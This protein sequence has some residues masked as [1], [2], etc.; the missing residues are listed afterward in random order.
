[1]QKNEFIREILIHHMVHY[2]GIFKDKLVHYD[3]NVN[4]YLDY[5]FHCLMFL[6]NHRFIDEFILNLP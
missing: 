6:I 1:M 2:I 5:Y 3:A 4:S